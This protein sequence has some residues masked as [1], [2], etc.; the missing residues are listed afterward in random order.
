MSQANIQQKF[1]SASSEEA[2]RSGYQSY[3]QQDSYTYNNVG[4]QLYNP[5][6]PSQFNQTQH[7]PQP[8][9]SLKVPIKPEESQAES[10]SVSQDKLERLRI[11]SC[12]IVK[13]EM[14][15]TQAAVETGL[16][17][18]MIKTWVGSLEDI[19]ETNKVALE[20]AKKYDALLVNYN[21][22]KRAVLNLGKEFLSGSDDDPVDLRL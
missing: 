13:N 17:E 16:S 10:V 11:I 18:E 19:L 12:K 20:K 6:P 4:A 1:F 15:Q 21:K 9:S 2:W 5:P 22:M 3:Q 7:Q 8:A 14:S